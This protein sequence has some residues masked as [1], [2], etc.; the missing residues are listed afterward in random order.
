MM[1]KNM[2]VEQYA[3]R[4]LKRVEWANEFGYFSDVDWVENLEGVIQDAFNVGYGVAQEMFNDFLLYNV[5]EHEENSVKVSRENL[6][7]YLNIY[8]FK[9]II[10]AESNA[11]FYIQNFIKPKVEKHER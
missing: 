11:H 3:Q 7:W 5:I 9:H 1:E 4:F 10:K 6:V 8:G 2:L